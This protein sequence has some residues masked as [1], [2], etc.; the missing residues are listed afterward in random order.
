MLCLNI[1][2]V[3]IIT[4]KYFDYGYIIHEIDKSEA[5]HL[6]D[7]SVFDDRGYI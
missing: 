5:I 6:L 2:D 3:T 1:S 4:V 7:I